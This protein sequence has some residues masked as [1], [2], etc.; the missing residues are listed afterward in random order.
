MDLIKENKY[1][2]LVLVVVFS[3]NFYS[4]VLWSRPPGP[5]IGGDVYRF[6]GLA[7]GVIEGRS[8]LY[9]DPFK[10]EI[11]YYAWLSNVLFSYVSYITG[12]D[13]FETF[14][15][16]ISFT[17]IIACLSVYVAARRLFSKRIAVLTLFV[18]FGLQN[19]LAESNPRDF[20]LVLFPLFVW[21]F[22][23]YY[24]TGDWRYFF[25]LSVL[26]GAIVQ[27]S[28]TYAG[29]IAMPILFPII[30][31][32]RKYSPNYK[33]TL[34]FLF[35]ALFF[36]S[37]FILPLYFQ[38]GLKTVEVSTY[39]T[40]P[41][42]DP[43]TKKIPVPNSLF[44]YLSDSFFQF[45][46]IASIVFTLSNFYLLFLLL[47]SRNEKVLYVG[48]FL[49]LGILITLSP[50]LTYP[51]TGSYLQHSGD[52][53][54]RVFLSSVIISFLFSKNLKNKSMKYLIVFLFLFLVFGRYRPT[55]GSQWHTEPYHA[56]LHPIFSNFR[57]WT[58]EN[59]PIDAVFAASPEMSFAINGL[60]GR[61]VLV[62]L[63]SHTNDFVP[64]L[65]RFLNSTLL[66]QTLSDEEAHAIAK[67]WMVD[68]IYI[69]AYESE[70]YKEGI[71]KFA[72]STLFRLVYAEPQVYYVFEVT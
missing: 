59:T 5:I 51:S 17:V 2:F 62:T 38:Y 58:L 50:S 37:W 72:N 23:D 70:R 60:T 45:N 52:F 57:E 27:Y 31:V 44:E 47:T 20:A 40:T 33:R 11:T 9:N 54:P 34:A 15:L 66:F 10:G 61:H 42:A 4:A 53:I 13:V 14:L 25:S 64:Y 29:I 19:R 3:I 32:I 39:Y 6:T 35:P 21:L 28:N 12:F 43:F 46:S 56:P 16:L 65:P 1:L 22:Y 71:N 48:S 24:R 67:A 68:Y 26:F 55:L 49:L 30:L 69:G 8:V 41:D 7:Q 63:Y 36:V 18:Y